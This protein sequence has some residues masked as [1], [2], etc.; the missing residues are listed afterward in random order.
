MAASDQQNPRTDQTSGRRIARQTLHDEVVNQV[1]NMIIEGELSQGERVPERQLCEQ[2]GISRT[3]LREAL[4]VLASEG[5]VELLPN[6]GAR[7]TKLTLDDLQEIFEVLGA[8]EGLSGE[9]AAVRMSDADIAEVRELHDRMVDA[10]EKRERLEY[11]VLNQQIH[12]RIMDGAQSETLRSI[13][14]SI[15]GRVRHARYLTNLSEKRWKQAVNEHSAIIGA[16]EDRDSDK[17]F[18][19][20]RQHLRNKADV[21]KAAWI[22]GGDRQADARQAS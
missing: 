19:I 7:V 22:E 14:Q 20:L 10:Y 8:L 16:L 6:R 3:P 15:C 4:K 21:A 5:M 9:L 1:R 12:D 2:L 18:R 11:F 17:L 13:Y